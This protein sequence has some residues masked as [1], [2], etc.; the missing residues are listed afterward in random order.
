M[1]DRSTVASAR[2]Q[3]ALDSL[4]DAQTLVGRA[5]EALCSIQGGQ[6]VWTKLGRLYDQV[7][8]MW[9]VVDGFRLA[10]PRLLDREPTDTELHCPWSSYIDERLPKT[11]VND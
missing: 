6:R 5:A 2:L 9:Y 7:H 4:Q 3:Y 10:K 11:T 1:M 8:R